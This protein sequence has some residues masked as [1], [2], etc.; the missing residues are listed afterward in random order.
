M[1]VT[2]LR[3]RAFFVLGRFVRQNGSLTTVIVIMLFVTANNISAQN[4]NENYLRGYWHE[5]NAATAI[6][7]AGQNGT[8]YESG[9]ALGKNN[10]LSDTTRIAV[11]G[12]TQNNGASQ[13]T[14]LHALADPGE[15]LLSENAIVSDANYQGTDKGNTQSI[16]IYTVVEGDTL[17]TIAQKNNVSTAT[18]MWANDIDD[19]DD[20]APGDTLFILPVSGVKHIVLSSDTLSTI[21]DEY[22]ADEEDIIAFNSLPANGE[23][24][25]G[26]ELVIPGGAIEAPEPAPAPVVENP[27]GLAFPDASVIIPRREY[28]KT[29]SG[30][31][32]HP[33]PGARRTQGIHPTNAVDLAA[34]QGT[35]IVAAAGGTVTKVSGSGW[36]GGYGQHVIISHPN[37]SI[38]LYAHMSRI[39]TK[40]GASVK[41]GEVI[42]RV[43]STGRSTG[44]HVHFEVRGATNPF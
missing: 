37:G 41:Q 36:Q 30:Y 26:Q 25:E 19:V 35:P 43:G 15:S 24:K 38:T 20:I 12:D 3:G 16:A 11:A 1:L 2:L 5:G 18:I 32:T 23:I 28:T 29:S 33:A 44:S 14:D 7:V 22:E 13:T 27:N 17:S 6:P 39:D 9:L 34:P 21:S 42:G 8:D 4:I 31:F 10:V 40:K